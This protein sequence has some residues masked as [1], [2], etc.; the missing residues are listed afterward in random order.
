MVEPG[1]AF[2]SPWRPEPGATMADRRGSLCYGGVAI[3]A[4][5]RLG[6][7]RGVNGTRLRA[8]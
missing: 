7:V 8:A 3:L 2:S 4:G 6:G 1:V 5:T